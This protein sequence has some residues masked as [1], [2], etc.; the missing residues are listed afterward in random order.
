[1]IGLAVGDTVTGTGIPSGTTI[2]AIN[3]ATKTITLSASATAGGSQTLAAANPTATPDP[4]LLLATTYGQGQF[5]IN[6]AP[7]VLGNAVT[8]TQPPS[9]DPVPVGANGL[10]IVT[11]PITISGSSEISGFGNTTW[12]SIVDETLG[13]PTYGQVIGGFDPANAPQVPSSSNSTD[14]VGNFAI[15]IDP[16]TVFGTSSLLTHGVKTIEIFATDNAGS[17]GNKV[18]FTFDLNPATQLGFDPNFQVPATAIAGQ[19]FA[20]VT[21]D[22]LDTHGNIDP[23]Y[24]GS[25]T[26]TLSPNASSTFPVT[27]T[28]V[29][30]IA[31]FD[32]ADFDLAIYKTGTYALKASSGSLIGGTSSP[33]TITAADP[34]VLA[35][36]TQPPSKITVNNVFGTIP[37]LEVE[38]QYGNLEADYTQD[39]TVSLYLNGNLDNGDLSPPAPVSMPAVGGVAMFPGLSITAV[40]NPFNLVA[41][42]DTM[43]SGTLTSLPSADINVVP[44]VLVVTSQP[45][46]SVTA[47]TPFQLVVTAYTFMGAVDTAFNDPVVLSINSGPNGA[48]SNLPITATASSGV[49]TFSVPTSNPV[50]LDTA[51]P[52]ILE[53]SDSNFNLTVDTSTIT[54]VAAGVNSLV[55]LQEP[56]AMVQAR[57]LL[58]FGL[59][60]GAI[61]QFGNATTLTGNVTIQIATNPGGGTLGPPANLTVKASGGVATFSG[62]AISAVG[63]G[64]TL[65]ATSGSGTFTSPPFDPDRRACSPGYCA[66]SLAAASVECHGPSDLW[67]PGRG[68]GSVRTV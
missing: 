4:D 27:G 19:N 24:N 16:N 6:L 15:T 43:T 41:T 57:S 22:A 36:T 37:T 42:S 3:S 28:A 38:D 53:A 13:D 29:A 11:D 40:G 63:D 1:M 65:V 59:V 18:T 50:I 35:W 12:I 48:M 8:V 9:T 64:Y 10:P 23:Y 49:A 45:L 66:P 20:P 52:Y 30:G 5:A 17:V 61:D 25:V 60:V 26:L 21:V 46:N 68:F 33:I 39:V 44:P 34:A 14:S 67:L 56:P 2:L 7:L 31:T 32:A 54:V 55:F 62:L 47:G 58:G 51:G